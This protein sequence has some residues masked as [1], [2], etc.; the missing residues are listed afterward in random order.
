MSY[1]FRMI[2]REILPA[3]EKAA[4]QYKAVALTGPR[5][6]GPPEAVS[7][8]TRHR[9]SPARAALVFLG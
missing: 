4:R 5:Q 7:T 9:L 3:L 1:R 8:P 2:F 6:S